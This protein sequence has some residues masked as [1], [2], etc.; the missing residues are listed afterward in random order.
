LHDGLEVNPFTGT[1]AGLMLKLRRGG[2]E[3]HLPSL[4]FA[5]DTNVLPWRPG[6]FGAGDAGGA[7]P[8]PFFLPDPVVVSVASVAVLSWV[9]AS[10]SAALFALFFFLLDPARSVASLARLR[11][12]WAAACSASATAATIPST[13]VSMA[14]LPW[15]VAAA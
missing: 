6:D 14:V 2:P 12:P 15:V 4:G 10:W 8:A 3:E 11:A 5:D 1:R 7:F 9:A 13:P